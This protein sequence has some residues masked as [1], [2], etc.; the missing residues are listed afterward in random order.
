MAAVFH[1]IAGIAVFAALAAWVAAFRGGRAAIA[2]D[3]ADG[4][5]S[6]TGR[7]LLLAVWPFAVRRQGSAGE[8]DR[9]R[10]GKAAIVFF[11]SLTIAVASF[12]AYSNLTFKSTHVAPTGALPAAPAGV[13]SKS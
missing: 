9:V 3:R 1:I 4:L 2:A 8:A 7:H 6:G 12:S 13:P 5:P 11:V 10:T